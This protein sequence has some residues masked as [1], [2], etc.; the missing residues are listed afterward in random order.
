MKCEECGAVK[1]ATVRIRRDK[2]IHERKKLLTVCIAV[3]LAVAMVCGTVLGC[4]TVKKQQETIIEQ[5]YALN[6]QYAQ[7][8]E[9]VAGAEV[10]TETTSNEANADGGGTAVAGNDNIVA[11]GDVNG[12]G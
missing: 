5:Q 8:M 10:T 9:Y 12:A 7:L 1:D 3:L 2:Q 11:G 4:Y 6:M